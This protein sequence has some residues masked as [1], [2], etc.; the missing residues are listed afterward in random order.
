ML[1]PLGIHIWLICWS[2]VYQL[3]TMTLLISIG[4]N[5]DRSSSEH[6][7]LHGLEC[8]VSTCKIVYRPYYQSTRCQVYP[9][10][11]YFHTLIAIIMYSIVPMYIDDTIR[12][13]KNKSKWSAIISDPA[14]SHRQM[15]QRG[16]PTN[17]VEK[18]KSHRSL[19]IFPFDKTRHSQP[20]L[21]ISFSSL[22]WVPTISIFILPNCILDIPSPWPPQSLS[23]TPPTPP[24]P[25]SPSSRSPTSAAC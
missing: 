4:Q 25:D 12:S 11:Y 9:I 22:D 21:G 8:S 23:P 18:E 5:R 20:V 14:I 1:L 17:A 10:L 16:G 13:T 6:G 7:V 19:H 2:K 24:P 3:R 15:I